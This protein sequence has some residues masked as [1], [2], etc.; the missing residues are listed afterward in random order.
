VLGRELPVGLQEEEALDE[1]ACGAKPQ[2]QPQDNE[3]LG[4]QPVLATAE[5]VSGVLEAVSS[6]PPGSRPRGA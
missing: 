1:H 3:E 4:R 6:G 2:R 5:A